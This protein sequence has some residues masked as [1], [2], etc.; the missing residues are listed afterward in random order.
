MLVSGGLFYGIYQELIIIRTP[1]RTI[2]PLLN[3]LH[4]QKSNFKL[5]YWKD[6][7]WHKEE[8]EL[9]SSDNKVQTLHYLLTSWLGLLDEEH[10][11]QR[12]TSIQSIMLDSSGQEAFISFDCNPFQKKSST[13][14][15]WLWAEG[16][17]KTIRENNIAIQNVRFLVHHQPLHDHHIDFSHAWPLGGFLST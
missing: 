13:Y 6:K 11:L 9:I 16:L 1:F 15:K 12:K 14:D 4:V 10:L 5:V 3:D 8:K 2:A 17:L 7:S